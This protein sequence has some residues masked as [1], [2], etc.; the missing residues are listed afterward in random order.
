MNKNKEPDPWT[1]AHISVYQ[2][3]YE[4]IEKEHKRK[5]QLEEEK[6]QKQIDHEIEKEIDR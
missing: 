1:K 4:Q 2:K 3:Y 6:K 5:M